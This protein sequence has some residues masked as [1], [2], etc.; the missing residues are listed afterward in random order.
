MSPTRT[1]TPVRRGEGP[2]G[3]SAEEEASVQGRHAVQLVRYLEKT[4]NIPGPGADL[5]HLESA[6]AVWGIDPQVAEELELDARDNR[7]E[8]VARKV[9]GLEPGMRLSALLML[10][11][12][13][14][15]EVGQDAD[16]VIRSMLAAASELDQIPATIAAQLLGEL[17]QFEERRTLSAEDLKGAL[18]LATAA[19]SEF[20]TERYLSRVQGETD[21]DL[22]LH[23]LGRAGALLD[24]HAA[25]LAQ[26]TAYCVRTEGER[27]F[28]VLEELGEE[29]VSGLLVRAGPEVVGTINRH[30]KR[31]A[32]LESEG[33]ESQARGHT[34]VAQEAISEV[35]KLAGL[36]SKAVIRALYSGSRSPLRALASGGVF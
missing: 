7:G 9:A 3:L 17:D 30:F 33:N 8:E 18:D 19:G 28:A 23:V 20:A 32:E 13:A 26:V 6:G 25:A 22:S 4:A 35:S 1:M 24:H 10:S 14:R 36:F 27:A 34:L 31:A 21:H 15:E 5:I 12:L 11:R 2:E 29:P 16:N